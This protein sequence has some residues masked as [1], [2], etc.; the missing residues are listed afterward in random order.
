[1]ASVLEAIGNTPL[2]D[3]SRLTGSL[4]GRILLKLEYLNPG[5]SKKDRAALGVIAEAASSGELQPGQTVV[6]LT[7]GNM[8][9]GLAIVCAVKGHPLVTVMSRGNSAERPQAV[10]WGPI[11]SLELLVW[12]RGSPARILKA[13]SADLSSPGRAET[14]MEHSKLLPLVGMLSAAA[15]LASCSVIHTMEWQ[16]T[17]RNALLD[18]NAGKPVSH[19]IYVDVAPGTGTTISA[20][21]IV[22]WTDFTQT[23]AYL[24]TVSKGCPDLYLNGA[25]VTTTGDAVWAHADHVIAAGLFR[26]DIQSIQPVDWLKAQRDVGQMS[27]GQ[28]AL[29]GNVGMQGG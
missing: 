5:F 18:A 6:E 23:H 17:T 7:S 26:C 25:Y 19:I 9:T 2:V 4:S 27:V 22:T 14:T 11:K 13:V 12:C 24:I 8:G 3:L 1:M 21:Q 15:L 20:N 16:K 10:P 28:H 29:P